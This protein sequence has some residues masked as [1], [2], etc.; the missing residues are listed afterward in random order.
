V[1][2]SDLRARA[3]R[4]AA[5]F[6]RHVVE[7]VRNSRNERELQTQVNARLMAF[8]ASVGAALR[9]AISAGTAT[10]VTG[11]AFGDVSLGDSQPEVGSAMTDGNE[12]DPSR[13]C[14]WCSAPVPPDATHCPACGA[15]LSQ[16]ESLGDLAIPGVT[17]VDP[18][19]QAYAAEP[20]PIPTR[21]TS[22]SSQATNLPT[23]RCSCAARRA[24]TLRPRPSA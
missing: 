20:L 16:R 13:E 19:L 22:L 6:E 23:T 1:L 7:A 9:G 18:A 5:D 2:E 10:G 24:S 11:L 15:A 12:T 21:V 8:A 3:E 4:E 17:T 14:P